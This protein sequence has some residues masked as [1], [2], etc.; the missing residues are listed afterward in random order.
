MM[1][2]RSLNVRKFASGLV[3]CDW[4][5]DPGVTSRKLTFSAILK[6]D[7]TYSHWL[8]LNGGWYLPGI[9]TAGSISP[10]AST[11]SRVLYSSA[12]ST[13]TDHALINVTP[14]EYY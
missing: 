12:I 2:L 14:L 5:S 10:D 8:M 6:A 4:F 13:G 11:L 7:S 3:L 1:L 9:F